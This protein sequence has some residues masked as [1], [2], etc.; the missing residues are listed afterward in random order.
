ME[1]LNMRSEKEMMDLIM[2][3]A[4]EDDRIRAVIMNGSRTNPNAKKDIFQDY[5]IVYLVTNVQSFTSDHSLV[6]RFGEMM[7]MQMPEDM[8]LPAADNDGHFTYLMQFTDGN[9]IDLSLYPL[10]KADELIKGDGLSILLLDKDGTIE[11]LPPAHDSDYITKAPT[12]KEFLNCCNE[13]WWVSPYVAKGIWRE[14]LPYAK[15]ML[16]GPVRDML[17]K[18]LKWHIGI[19]TNFSKSSGKCGK[20]FKNYLEPDIWNEFVATYPNAEYE[21]I[22][23]SLFTMCDLFR[24][25]AISVA[26]HFGYTYPIID[27][28]KVTKHLNHVKHLPKNAEEIYP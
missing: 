2:N 21:N 10:E 5:D 15:E 13:F 23:Q 25:V 16:E 11:P 8:V 7:I 20:Y 19:K 9:R 12:E 18:M 22:W 14:E 4:K 6:N 3:T 27:D 17:M 1:A 24:K 26:E 28:E